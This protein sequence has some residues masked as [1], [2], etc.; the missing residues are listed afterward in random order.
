MSYIYTRF[1]MRRFVVLTSVN[2]MSIDL[3][4]N[5]MRWNWLNDAQ[6]SQNIQW[7]DSFLQS[8]KAIFSSLRHDFT[9]LTVIMSCNSWH[10]QCWREQTDGWCSVFHLLLLK[11]KMVQMLQKII[12]TSPSAWPLLPIDQWDAVNGS[13]DQSE[14]SIL[15]NWP[16]R[17]QE[18][19]QVILGLWN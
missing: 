11:L 6:W 14:A 16:M 10:G 15:T 13:I 12:S 3:I 18:M 1:R 7:I 19:D 8:R 17:T 4:I 2:W 9:C 5:S